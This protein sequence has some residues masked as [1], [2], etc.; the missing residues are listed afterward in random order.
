MRKDWNTVEVLRHARH[1]WLNKLQLIKGNIA[2]NKM[3]RAKEIID[4][5]VVEAQNEAKLSNLKMPELAS[6]L[7]TYNWENHSFQL[8]YEVVNE[9][10]PSPG[11]DGLI[12]SWT[13]SFFSCLNA[14]IEVFRE[15]HLSVTIEPGKKGI[16]FFFDFSGIITNKQ[17]LECFLEANEQAVSL[18]IQEFS[19][20]ELALEVFVPSGQGMAGR[21]D[22]RLGKSEDTRL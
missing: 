13:R 14:S 12:S 11:N 7:L 16:R 20:Q 2:L 4:E 6:L 8:E 3:E 18:K 1:D 15:N 17:Q 9:Q 21:S 5:I 10:E 22:S 19:E